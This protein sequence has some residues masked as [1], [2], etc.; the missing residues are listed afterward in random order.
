MNNRKAYI[1]KGSTIIEGARKE[2]IE[3]ITI[4]KERAEKIKKD[5]NNSLL[6]EI[7]KGKDIFDLYR[8]K[9]DEE[10]TSW[11]NMEFHTDKMNED[12]YTSFCYYRYGTKLPFRIE[13]SE[14]V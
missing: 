2:W 4:S 3:K 11:E 5:L 6:K 13:E 14:L 9:K 7:E 8:K 12:E 1:I 10:S